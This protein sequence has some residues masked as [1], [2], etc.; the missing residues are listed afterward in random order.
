MCVSTFIKA[1]IRAVNDIFDRV[2]PIQKDVKHSDIDWV[3]GQD[4]QNHFV[5]L[6]YLNRLGVKH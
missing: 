4:T 6:D 5:R 2:P 1:Q 3:K